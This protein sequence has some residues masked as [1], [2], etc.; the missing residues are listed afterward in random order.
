MPKCFQSFRHPDVIY[1][2]KT[3]EQISSHL[4]KNSNGKK[5]SYISNDSEQ[6]VRLIS[7][8]KVMDLRFPFWKPAPGNSNPSFVRIQELNANLVG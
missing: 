2:S 4:M 8:V 6:H 7:C 3:A 1:I 5:S